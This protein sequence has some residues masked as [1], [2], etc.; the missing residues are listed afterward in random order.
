M[1]VDFHCTRVYN[2]SGLTQRTHSINCSKM[3]QRQ[4]CKSSSLLPESL[5]YVISCWS[6]N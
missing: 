2:V 1:P 3:M 6:F 4:G 5:L